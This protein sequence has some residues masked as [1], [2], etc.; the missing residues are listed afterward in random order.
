[1]DYLPGVLKFYDLPRIAGALAPQ[2][3]WLLNPLDGQRKR[4]SS[5]AARGAYLFTQGCYA[6]RGS[7]GAFQVR[8]YE[9]DSE[10]VAATVAWA[11]SVFE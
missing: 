10:R 11:R 4:I 7:A 5:D 1:M 2:P 3:L 8:Q 9:T 6:V